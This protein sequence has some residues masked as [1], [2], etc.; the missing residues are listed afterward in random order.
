MII[1]LES[2][3]TFIN[4]YQMFSWYTSDKHYSLNIN[5]EKSF[6]DFKNNYRSA[7]LMYR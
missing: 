3:V 6:I 2:R 7:V 5:S 1:F 4:V